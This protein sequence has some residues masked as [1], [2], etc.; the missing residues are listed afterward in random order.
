MN[1]NVFCE[2]KG[3]SLRKRRRKNLDEE[4]CAAVRTRETSSRKRARKTLDEKQCGDVRSRIMSSRKRRRK[5]L[6]EQYGDVRSN[7]M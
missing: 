6:V 5:N 4:E 2:I 1:R 7:V 3:T